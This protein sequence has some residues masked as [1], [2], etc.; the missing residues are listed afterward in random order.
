MCNCVVEV[1]AK[2]A[3]HLESQGVEI[4]GTPVMDAALMLD[5]MQLTTSTKIHY[6]QKVVGKKGEKHVKKSVDMTQQFCP[7]CGED[8]QKHAAYSASPGKSSKRRTSI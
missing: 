7:F 1:T 2:V 5:S 3:S 4:V 8:K 6:V